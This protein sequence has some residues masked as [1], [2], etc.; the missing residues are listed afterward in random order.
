MSDAVLDLGGISVEAA[1][2]LGEG[3]SIADRR[4]ERVEANL[5]GCIR[6]EDGTEIACSIR[7]VSKSGA[8]L[9]VPRGCVLPRAFLFRIN[10]RDFIFQ[11]RLAWQREPYAGVR[12]ER[13]VRLSSLA[14]S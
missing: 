9:G 13:I 3:K 5:L 4:E 14:A 1:V 10:G 7:D 8:K 11:V 2:G 6:L 12:I